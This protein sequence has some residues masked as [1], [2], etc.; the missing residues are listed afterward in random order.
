MQH[1][2]HYDNQWQ[3]E[4]SDKI[5]TK[6]CCNVIAYLK[7][8]SDGLEPPHFARHVMVYVKEQQANVDTWR[9]KILETMGGKVDV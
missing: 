9:M 8:M 1:R 5:A 6:C 4:R 3:Q 2:G 7:D